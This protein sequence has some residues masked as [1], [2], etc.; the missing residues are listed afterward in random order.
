MTEAKTSGFEPARLVL[1]RARR[2][3]TGTKLAEECGVS[4]QALRNWEAA[5]REPNQ[6][7]LKKLSEV[8]RV[9]VGFFTTPPPEPLEPSRAN[10]RSRTKMSHRDRDAALAAGSMACE[11]ADFALAKF[12]LPAVSIPSL[13]GMRADTAADMVRAEWGL[14]DQPVANVIHLLEAKG[15]LVFS[16]AQDCA[17]VDA[18]S[19]WHRSRPVVMLNTMKSPD[20][21]RMDAAHELGHLVLH[22]HETGREQ[23]AEADSFGGAFLMPRAG[24]LAHRPQFADLRTLI[25]EKRRW[26][27]SLAAFVF[28]LHRLQLLSDWQYRRL[29]I[30]ISSEGFRTNE[31][32]PVERE[33]SLVWNKILASLRTKGVDHRRIAADL[34]WS[35]A[36]LNEF[37]FG[38]GA[39]FSR[40]DGGQQGGTS[41]GNLRLVKG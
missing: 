4:E 34:N 10:F 36:D 28:R 11:L 40:I 19:F 39:T 12:E 16:L 35:T 20:R 17:E 38:L 13:V 14:G 2:R 22:A 6:D 32:D 41:T 31:P 24:V 1:A 18:F 27:A 3:L 8:L 29:F 7:N 30:E 26:G 23:E 15:V 9:P 5:R 25:R 33:M 37:L 21:S